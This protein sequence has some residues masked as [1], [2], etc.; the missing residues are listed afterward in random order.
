MSRSDELYQ[1]AGHYNLNVMSW[2]SGARRKYSIM[3]KATGSELAVCVGLRQFELW[4]DGFAR[5]RE[6]AA[7]NLAE[8][9]QDT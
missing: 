7:R 1:K 4:L 8:A 2:R 6:H 5:G 9:L 3:D